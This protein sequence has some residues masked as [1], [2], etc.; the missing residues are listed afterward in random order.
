MHGEAH[1][2]AGGAAI[3][4]ILLTK[5]KGNM[6]AYTCICKQIEMG[7]DLN[8]SKCNFASTSF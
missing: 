7:P 4:Q 5:T 3:S 8:T 2:R 1:A 6:T